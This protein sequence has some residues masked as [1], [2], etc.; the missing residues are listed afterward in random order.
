LL[1]QRYK[2]LAFA[3]LSI[4]ARPNYWIRKR[5]YAI[6]R[7]NGRPLHLHVGC[8][9]KY[10]EGF[11]NIDINLSRRIDLWLDVRVGL[12]FASRS[13]DSIYS[14]HTFE[15]FYTNELDRVLSEC[16]RVLKPGG[17]IRLIVPSLESAIIAF[18]QNRRDWFSDFPRHFDSLGG[19]FS[20]FMFCDGQHRVAFDFTYLQE[21]LRRSGFS[22][23]ELSAEGQS[24]VY[25]DRVPEFEPSDSRELPHSLYVEAFRE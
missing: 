1:H 20:N 4:A 25:G 8:G 18:Q 17:G 13:V 19:R 23:V 6:R 7:A 3:G 24:R 16:A 14:T 9:P 10:L 11:V 22:Q 2:N 15:H 5:L 21:I 12:P